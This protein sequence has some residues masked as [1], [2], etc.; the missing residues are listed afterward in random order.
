MKKITIM[1]L[2]LLAS[3]NVAAQKVT[4]ASKGF[5]QGVKAHLKLG[6]NDDVLQT[7]TDTITKIDLSGLEISTVSDVV[8]LP[9]V[10]VLD[11]S[12]NGITDITPLA[13]LTALQELNL[14]NNFLHGIGMLAFSQSEKM[15]VNVT[16]NYIEDFTAL[17]LPSSCQFTVVGMNRQQKEEEYTFDVL[18]LYASLDEQDQL[19]V[20]YRGS[21]NMTATVTISAGETSETAQLDG[22]THS[23]PLS[24]VKET[25]K[26]LLTNGEKSETTYVVPTMNYSVDAGKTV[27]METGLPDDY[28]IE[29]AY[30][31]KGAI[32]IDGNTMKYTAPAEAVS[33]VINFTYYQ[34]GTLKGFSRYYVNKDMTSI[35]PG[36]A[37]GDGKVDVAD[38]VEMVNAM[39]GMPSGNYNKAAADMDGNGE[40]DE[41]DIE[42]VT[43]IIME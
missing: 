14:K 21:S 41:A 43:K 20:T 22:T 15:M 36:D 25:T 16:N 9:N 31:G 40:V 5:E 39:K 12:N 10:Q 2:S 38:I 30:A 35:I 28:L 8:W 33:D 17:L 34:G 13:E 4:F 37:N 26:A 24:G 19:K 6:E 11:L 29:S 3:L 27:A 18:Q 1:A 32:E 7:Q 42:A 23:L